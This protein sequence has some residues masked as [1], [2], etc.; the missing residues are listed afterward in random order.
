MMRKANKLDFRVL[1]R[2]SILRNINTGGLC[3]SKIDSLKVRLR[4]REN[5]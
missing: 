5:Y 1:I 2:D 4:E 3:S